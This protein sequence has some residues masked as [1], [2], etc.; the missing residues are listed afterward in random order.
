MRKIFYVV[1][2]GVLVLASAP[3]HAQESGTETSVLTDAQIDHI[4]TNCL[5][6][7]GSLGR[8]HANDGLTRVNLGR[9]LDAISSRLMAPLNARI[10][11]NKLDGVELAKT[12]VE[13]TEEFKKFDTAY[14]DYERTLSSAIDLNCVNQPV[15]FYDTLVRAYSKRTSVY[16]SLLKL[17]ELIRQYRAQFVVFSESIVRVKKEQSP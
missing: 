9:Q 5:S 2:V 3:V 1:L 13:Y 12:T 15:A 14:R 11:V 17:E 8:I 7:Q 6:V 16:E 4:R 10:A